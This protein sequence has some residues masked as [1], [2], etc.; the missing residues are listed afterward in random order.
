MTSMSRLRQF[1]KAKLVHAAE[2]VL[3]TGV[4]PRALGPLT[5]FAAVRGLDI[6]G[7][8]KCEPRPIDIDVVLARQPRE[9]ADVDNP[10]CSIVIPVFNKAEYTR[11]CIESLIREVR[12]G[13]TEIIVVDN[14][15]TDDTAEV[16][17]TFGD[18][19][20]VI[21][22]EE[23]LFFVRGCNAGAARARGKYLVFLNNDTVVL[24]GWLDH[25]VWTIERD[26]TIGAVGSMFLYPDGRVQEAGSIIWRNGGADH[27]GGGGSPLS[28]KVSYARD[29]DYC[30]GASLLVRRH[31][32]EQRGGFDEFYSPGYYEDVDLCFAIRDLGYRVVYQPT[33]R[34]VHFE[35]VTS[36]TDLSAGMKKFQTINQ[37]KFR[38]KWGEIL[39]REHYD[40]TKKNIDAAANRKHSS[41]TYL[42]F[43]EKLPRPD[44]DA[45]S[46]RMLHILEVL[47]R[48]GRV[49]F[50]P[51]FGDMDRSA[52]ELLWKRGIETAG[53]PFWHRYAGAKTRAAILSRPSVAD[54][55][56]EKVRRLNPKGAI[57]YDMVDVHFLRLTREMT[58]TSE[59]TLAKAASEA[60]S[61]EMDCARRAD[62]TWCATVA[63]QGVMLEK[64]PYLNTVVV[65]TIH[66]PRANTQPFAMRSGLLFVGNMSHRPNR[67]GVLYFLRHVL[68]LLRRSLPDAV[69]RIV[70]S[71]ADNEIT[72][73]ASADVHVLG[74]VADLEPIID[75]A[76]VFVAPL[77]FGA[78]SK[79]KIGECMAAGLP[80]V[81]SSIGAEGMGLIHRRNAMIADEPQNFADAIHELYKNESLWQQIADN[82]RS[83]VAKTFSPD[84]VGDVIRRSVQTKGP[85]C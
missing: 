52:E 8:A 41:A 26:D 68:P 38:R 74:H 35:G 10:L 66:V 81:T 2:L 44:R 4:P 55:L 45:G 18:A 23:N 63:D 46:L 67:D 5:R 14:A 36:G 79:G 37:G 58:T 20:R 19:V 69:I 65:P 84:A 78:G 80:V 73:F 29:V 64:A 56:I 76:R 53:M 31:L 40:R 83:H 27:Y 28:R 75:G 54:L 50:V 3:K 22:N 15:S 60:E 85:G 16:L 71:G 21:T 48:L 6:N 42:V 59:P 25:L 49:I 70:G 57:V 33:S 7:L 9:R 12:P 13:E 11:Q 43:D 30:S 72:A 1:A 62:V 39:E 51:V 24:P 32:F 34:I 77:R 61:V 82:A 17:R 47:A